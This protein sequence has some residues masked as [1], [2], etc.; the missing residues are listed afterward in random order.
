MD[1]IT[2]PCHNRGN[3]CWQK[4]K[5]ITLTSFDNPYHP[6]VSKSYGIQPT[7]TSQEIYLSLN[8]ENVINLIYIYLIFKTTL[9]SK[10]V[11]LGDDRTIRNASSR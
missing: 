2:Y 4:G 8:T 9:C 3:L 7:D 5:V 1:V 10:F 11:I 6:T